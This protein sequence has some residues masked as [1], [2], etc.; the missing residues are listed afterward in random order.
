MNSIKIVDCLLAYLDKE[1]IKKNYVVDDNYIPKTF[2]VVCNSTDFSDIFQRI[3]SSEING[4]SFHIKDISTNGL[5]TS[6]Y[7][8][9]TV[10]TFGNVYVRDDISYDFCDSTTTLLIPSNVNYKIPSNAK[11]CQATH[12]NI[13]V[14][15][16]V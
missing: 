14:W 15:L 6:F 4:F 10:D 16:N 12:D 1:I 13:P 2:T 3:I 9:I 8:Y 7:Y 5:S 11:Q